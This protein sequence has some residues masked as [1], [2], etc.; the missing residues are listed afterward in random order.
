[1]GIEVDIPPE[2][3]RLIVQ[4]AAAEGITFDSALECLVMEGIKSIKDANPYA[5]PYVDKSV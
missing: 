4:Y 1:M 2:T 5:Y 3:R